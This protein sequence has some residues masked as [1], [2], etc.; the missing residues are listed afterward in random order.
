[1][2]QHQNIYMLLKRFTFFLNIDLLQ[3]IEGPSEEPD[4]HQGDSRK[5][6]DYPAFVNRQFDAVV[7]CNVF[8]K[9]SAH[10]PVSAPH[11]LDHEIKTDDFDVISRNLQSIVK[12][13]GFYVDYCSDLFD[14]ASK[15]G[16][17]TVTRGYPYE[18]AHLILTQRLLE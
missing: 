5:L 11:T 2:V 10:T 14:I 3:Y 8:S 6:N 15:G 17:R 13:G 1:M 7:A 16:F 4:V 18:N 9:G 12:P